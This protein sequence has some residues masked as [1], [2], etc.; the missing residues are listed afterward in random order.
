MLRRGREKTMTNMLKD[1]V[2]LVTGA[3]GGTK[4]AVG[5]SA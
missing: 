5:A 3:G 4:V 2:V 1:K